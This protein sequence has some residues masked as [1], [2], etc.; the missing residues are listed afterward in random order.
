MSDEAP[1]MRGRVGLIGPTYAGKTTYFAVLDRALRDLDWRVEPQSGA[2]RESST[3]LLN[4]IRQ[5]MNQGYFPPKTPDRIPTDGLFFS[6]TK[7]MGKGRQHFD[8]NFFDPPGEIFE[9]AQDG[10][11]S[12]DITEVRQRFFNSIQESNG[13]LVL[14]DLERRPHELINIWTHSIESLIAHL[15]HHKFGIRDDQLDMRVAVV[16]TKADRLPW[17]ARHRM[18]NASAWLRG[19]EGLEVLAG[20]IRRV[21]PTVRFYFTSAV[22]WNRGQPN[23]RTV[24][25]PRDI[26]KDNLAPE[27]QSHQQSD[28]IPDPATGLPIAGSVRRRATMPLF[29]DPLRLIADDLNGGLMEEHVVGV[30]TLPGRRPPTKEE[31]RFLTPWNIVQ[32]LLWAAG[33][34]EFQ[35]NGST[36]LH[37]QNAT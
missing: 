18:R 5:H 6:V 31:E 30:I 21:C 1:K 23:C 8:L 36:N 33:V 29:S 15:R 28:L 34:E 12:Q 13:L 19:N 10:L 27:K 2:R 4:Y 26:V 17:M 24:I 35:P 25:R 20:D 32:P 7:G 3:R 16:F 22:G 14:L 37:W 11:E 9:P